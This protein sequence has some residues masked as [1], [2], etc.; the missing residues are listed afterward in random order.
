MGRR[1]SDGDSLQYGQIRDWVLSGKERIFV[2]L[3]SGRLI[4]GSA[5]LD[6][7]FS[8]DIS[9]WRRSHQKLFFHPRD[10][11]SAAIATGIMTIQSC[12]GCCEVPACD[13]Q[14]AIV[15]RGLDAH[16]IAARGRRVNRHN[17]L[18]LTRAI[19]TYLQR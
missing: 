12:R 15:G 9:L 5:A 3:W 1:L 2:R 11:S 8:P 7:L 4:V 6:L 19:G 17:G 18:R 13:G 16:K 14:A 10:G